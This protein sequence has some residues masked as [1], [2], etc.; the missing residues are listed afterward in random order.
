MSNECSISSKQKLTANSIH[1]AINGV[2]LLV[3]S[4]AYSYTWTSTACVLP[5]KTKA[6]RSGYEGNSLTF[7]LSV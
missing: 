6:V 5:T 3:M 1:N 2:C 7:I 4:C